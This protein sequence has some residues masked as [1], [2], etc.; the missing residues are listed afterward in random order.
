MR[1]TKF[2]VAEYL[3]SPEAIAGYLDAVFE[4]GDP[5][6]IAAALGHVAR[7]KGMSQIAAD[8]GLK[9]PAL[10]RALS[11]EGNPEFATV[12][13]VMSALGVRISATPVVKARK[14]RKASAE[15]A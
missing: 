15:A 1:T 7:A 13:K 6:L 2:D 9:R 11:A 3:D 14:T 4:D 12:L 8:T 5:A 10:Y